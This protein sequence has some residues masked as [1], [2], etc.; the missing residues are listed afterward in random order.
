MALHKILIGV[1]SLL[2]RIL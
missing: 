1:L 2:F